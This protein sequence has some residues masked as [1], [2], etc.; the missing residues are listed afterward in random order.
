MVDFQYVISTLINRF[1]VKVSILPSQ[2]ESDCG[3]GNKKTLS[4]EV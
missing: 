2:Y 1:L 4:K 3:R